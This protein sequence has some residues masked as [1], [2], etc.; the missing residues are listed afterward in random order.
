MTR[1]TYL[2]PSSPTV[3]SPKTH[4]R[5]SLAQVTQRERVG[6]A[7][8]HLPSSPC[9]KDE[10]VLVRLLIAA[11]MMLMMT[12][13]AYAARTIDISVQLASPVSI[14][15]DVDAR[16]EAH[17]NA[18]E[19]AKAWRQSEQTLQ[20]KLFSVL[21]DQLKVVQDRPNGP[22]TYPPEFRRSFDRTRVLSRKQIEAVIGPE[23]QSVSLPAAPDVALTLTFK[24][25]S[26]TPLTFNPG[27]RSDAAMIKIVI[28]GDGAYRYRF[29]NR[30]TTREIRPG[31]LV[32]LAPDATHTVKLSG[33][34]DGGRLLDGP[35][36]LRKP[37]RYELTVHYT[38]KGHLSNAE[39]VSG[40]SPAF[41]FEVVH[42][43]R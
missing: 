32:T 15:P 22:V 23:P 14:K 1:A 13:P 24:N 33:L 43:A 18:Y 25:R 7:P 3:R 27:L 8:R 21:F 12:T 5:G 9:H 11:T 16:L 17:L 30:I 20:R 34:N 38:M 42:A 2:R 28:K 39:P 6:Y 31:R 41:G 29:G 4:A 36:Y 10:G 37:G 40:V 35:W 19:A 26:R